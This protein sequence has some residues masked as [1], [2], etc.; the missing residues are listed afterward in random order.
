MNLNIYENR[1]ENEEMIKGEV[2]QQGLILESVFFLPL[3]N[4]GRTQ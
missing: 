2:G 3:G 1:K 4:R